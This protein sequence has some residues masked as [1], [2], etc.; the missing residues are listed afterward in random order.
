MS[1]KESL[2]KRKFDE[3]KHCVI[4][5]KAITVDQDFCSQECKDKYSKD[6]KKKSRSSTLQIVI[7]GVLL[8]VMLI[9]MTNF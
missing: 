1:W 3:H 7:F 6:D 5:R 9:V 4:C 2:K 8:V